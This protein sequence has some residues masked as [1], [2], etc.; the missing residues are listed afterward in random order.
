MGKSIPVITIDGPS[1]AG[2]GTVSR[3]LAE[4]LG[5]HLLDSGAIY[6]VLAL[7]AL[8]H[9]ISADDEDGLVALASD[10]D[11]KFDIE[12]EK[13]LTHIILEGEDVTFTACGNTIANMEKN[14]GRKITIMEEARVVPSGVVRLIEL[15][16]D[17]Y[18]YVRP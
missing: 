7:A 16:E 13:N 3:I 5:W 2:K 10:L 8:H 9:D 17:G 14:T 15:Q 1:G 6:R 12:D 18:A 11:V 4:K